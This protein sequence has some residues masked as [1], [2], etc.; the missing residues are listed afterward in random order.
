MQTETK[1]LEAKQKRSAKKTSSTIDRQTVIKIVSILLCVILYFVLLTTFF[2]NEIDTYICY[3]TNTGECYH[4]ATCQYLRQSRHETTVYQA[5]RN[6][7]SCSRC[8]PCVER[9]EITITDRNYFIQ[10]LISTAVSA[11]LYLL[12]TYRQRE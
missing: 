1:T 3:T 5:K 12:L 10:L 8:N 4:A 11:S 7:R 9:Y 2:S 6:Y